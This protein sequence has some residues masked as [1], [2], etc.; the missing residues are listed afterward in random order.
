MERPRDEVAPFILSKIS[1]A[2]A[3]LKFWNFNVPYKAYMALTN[4]KTLQLW[5]FCNTLVEEFFSY[6]ELITSCNL[7]I[8]PAAW[9]PSIWV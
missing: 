1:A 4:V 3:E 6:M 7:P 5:E 9:A 2:V 8:K